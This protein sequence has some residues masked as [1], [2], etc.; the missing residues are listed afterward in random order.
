MPDEYVQTK[1]ARAAVK[2]I[3]KAVADWTKQHTKASMRVVWGHA[4]KEDAEAERKLPKAYQRQYGL[5]NWHSL[6]FELMVYQL[7]DPDDPCLCH[8]QARFEEPQLLPLTPRNLYNVLRCCE[9]AVSLSVCPSMESEAVLV[10]GVETAV[11]VENLTGRVLRDVLARL[12]MS[13]NSAFECLA[14]KQGEDYW[15]LDG[16]AEPGAAPDL[17]G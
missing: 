17:G 8:L 3:E 5:I 6:D 2:S 12:R 4:N 13:H 1:R 15:T 7:G 14:K 16:G 11:P 10:F 9:D